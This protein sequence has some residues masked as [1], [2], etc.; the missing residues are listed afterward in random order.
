MRR[1]TVENVQTGAGCDIPNAD[2]LAR[3]GVGA[4][5]RQACAR[6]V[7]E[8]DRRVEVR[9]NR[10]TWLPGRRVEEPRPSA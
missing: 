7:E 10:S 2:H 5:E 1:V 4:H 3:I 8:R 6:G 9:A